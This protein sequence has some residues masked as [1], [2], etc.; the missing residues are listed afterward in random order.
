MAGQNGWFDIYSLFS[1]S[2]LRLYSPAM[3]EA[4]KDLLV[5]PILAVAAAHNILVVAVLSVAQVVVVEVV[6]GVPI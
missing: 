2:K 1:L 5:L 6:V 4:T 3:A